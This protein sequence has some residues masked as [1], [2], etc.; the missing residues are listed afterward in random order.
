[1]TAFVEVLTATVEEVVPAPIGAPAIITIAAAIALS[2]KILIDVLK[3][4]VPKA[5]AHARKVALAITTVAAAGIFLLNQL[6]LGGTIEQSVLLAGSAYG[7]LIVDAFGK[8]FRKK[9]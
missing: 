8:L 5:S 3:V 6:T 9:T 4:A 2:L 1:M 7:A